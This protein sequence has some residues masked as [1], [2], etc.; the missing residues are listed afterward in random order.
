[1][2]VAPQDVVGDVDVAG[3]HVVDALRDGDGPRWGGAGGARAASSRADG[4]RAQGHGWWRFCAPVR[5]KGR[6]SPPHTHHF[7]ALLNALEKL[8]LHPSQGRM[9][10]SISW[11]YEKEELINWEWLKIKRDLILPI[12]ELLFKKKNLS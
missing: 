7:I 11:F 9:S 2:L 3:S 1:M 8:T 12:N 5:G 10:S 6:V 4:G